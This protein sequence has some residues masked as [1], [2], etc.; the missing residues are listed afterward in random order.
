MSFL[1]YAKKGTTN[2]KIYKSIVL[3]DESKIT[4]ED[5]LETD[6]YG[7]T[8]LHIVSGDGSI[9]SVNMLLEICNKWNF[10]IRRYIMMKDIYGHTSFCIA[11]QKGHLSVLKILI[12]K[13]NL[14]KDDIMYNDIKNGMTIFSLF[15][16]ADQ[17]KGTHA[18]NLIM[19][20]NLN[21]VH[22]ILC[23]SINLHFTKNDILQSNISN[24]VLLNHYCIGHVYIVKSI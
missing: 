13:G 6:K 19:R 22:L 16:I 11:G 24:V 7:R 12:E 5:L 21:I 10:S 9:A 8:A 1:E 15:C 14:Q 18:L 3:Y 17:L 4:K 23:S 20:R 2:G